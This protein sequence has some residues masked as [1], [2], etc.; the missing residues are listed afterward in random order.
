MQKKA[1]LKCCSFT[2]ILIAVFVNA[3]HEQPSV[4]EGFVIDGRLALLYIDPMTVDEQIAE[5]TRQVSGQ[6]LRAVFPALVFAV[7]GLVV[8]GAWTEN[9]VLYAAAGVGAVL[10]FAVRQVVPHLSNAALG[11]REGWRQEG[12]VEIGIS[13]WKDA[14]S[15]EYETYEGR[16]AVAGQ[17]LWEMEFAQPRNWQP[18]QGRFEARLVFQRGVAWPVTADG[19]LYP[20]VRPRRAGRT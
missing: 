1:P 13:R 6:G 14:E 19:L 12:T 8:A 11:L 4:P 15:N 16:I 7:A 10:T 2:Y 17:P 9:P 18:V 3:F 5:L 20:R